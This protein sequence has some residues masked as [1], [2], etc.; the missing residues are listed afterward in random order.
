MPEKAGS[1]AFPSMGPNR[2]A[3]DTFA[4]KR[5]GSILCMI[6]II[7]AAALALSEN[8]PLDEQV[9]QA[10]N[11]PLPAAPEVAGVEVTEAAAE[12]GDLPKLRVTHVATGAWMN[13]YYD[14]SSEAAA[15]GRAACFGGQLALLEGEI[16]DSRTNAHWDD[17]VFTS[18]SDYAPPARGAGATRWIIGT[19]QQGELGQAAQETILSTLPHEQM[20][21]YQTRAGARLPRWVSEGHATWIGLK[22]LSRLDPVLGAA[23]TSKA[24]TNLAASTQPLALGEWGGVQP[25]REAILRQLSPEDR[26]RIENDPTFRPDGAF[27]FTSDDLISDESNSPARYGGA[28]KI[29]VDLEERYGAAAI[30][31][32]VA[33]V[34]SKEGGLRSADAAASVQSRFNEDITPLLR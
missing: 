32:W 13:V 28:W 33:E 17:V 2:D 14:A 5:T 22:V 30:N 6:S 29:F 8:P 16:G 27:R 10:C 9:S 34:T 3:A 15:R 7:F 19:T 24:R 20:H 4:K 21:A 1:V 12:E 25:K 18:R 23:E 26:V 11:A 31:G